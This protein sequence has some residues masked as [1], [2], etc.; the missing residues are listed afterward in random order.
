MRDIY[1]RLISLLDIYLTADADHTGEAVQEVKRGRSGECTV[2]LVDKIRAAE[3][4]V[5]LL[6][7]SALYPA[8]AVSVSYPCEDKEKLEQIYR[9]LK[10][11]EKRIQREANASESRD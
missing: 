2:V 3:L 8:G 7:S 4:L 6:D 11:Y 1:D 10:K 5:K 9:I